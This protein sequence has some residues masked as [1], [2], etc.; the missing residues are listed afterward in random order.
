MFVVQGLEESCIRVYEPKGHEASRTPTLWQEAPQTIETPHAPQ[1][2]A[3]HPW[4]KFTKCQHG[5]MLLVLLPQLHHRYDAAR[6]YLEKANKS[7]I[8][9]ACQNAAEVQQTPAAA[10]VAATQESAAGASEH[11]GL[12]DCLCLL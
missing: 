6:C 10:S 8:C 7:R 5:Q 3:A 9:T 11:K 2:I 4:V 12:Q 1:A